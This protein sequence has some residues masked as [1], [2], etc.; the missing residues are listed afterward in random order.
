MENENSRLYSIIRQIV[1][2]D[3]FTDKD[4][5]IAANDIKAYYDAGNPNLYSATY[6]WLVG[7]NE[8]DFEYLVERLEN[9]EEY[10]G[11][12]CPEKKEKFL[13][14]KDYILLEAL[15]AS[16]FADIRKIT[17]DAKKQ[18]V[19][20]RKIQDEF[21]EN[22]KASHSQSITV[23]SIFTGIAMAFFGGF[24]LLGSAFERLGQPGVIFSDLV[25]I[26]LIVGLIL[27]D[28]VYLL[29]YCASKINKNALVSSRH[30]N[31]NECQTNCQKDWRKFFSFIWRYPLPSSINIVFVALIVFLLIGRYFEIIVKG[32]ESKLI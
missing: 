1:S 24:S 21:E 29:I 3:K 14:L 20:T 17:N 2:K 6:R 28:T 27:F 15:R 13:K 22:R 9:I 8:D 30:A 25:L 32:I 4:A 11:D 31:C 19:E 5:E 16:D 26:I 12:A 18:L 7:S 10:F 23:L